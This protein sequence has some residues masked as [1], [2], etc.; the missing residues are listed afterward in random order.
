MAVIHTAV[1]GPRKWHFQ[2]APQVNSLVHCSQTAYQ[3]V[4]LQTGKQKYHV[5]I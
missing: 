3:Y 5:T 1:L 4:S 2:Q